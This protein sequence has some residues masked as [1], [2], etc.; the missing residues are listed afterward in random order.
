[1][2]IKNLFVKIKGY[3][4]AH[5]KKAKLGTGVLVVVVAL[6][7]WALFAFAQS[8]VDSFNDSTK[9]AATWQANVDTGAGTVSLQTKTCSTT[10]WFCSE[11]RDVRMIWGMGIIFWLVRGR[12]QLMPGRLQ[13]HIAMN[14]NALGELIVIRF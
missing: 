4:Q 2:E 9:I 14:R 5:P 13:I 10:Q 3:F 1:M 8:V 6:G 12:R 7:S 11:R